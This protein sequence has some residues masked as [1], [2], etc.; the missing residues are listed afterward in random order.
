MNI[1]YRSTETERQAEQTERN[2]WRK[3]AWRQK[4]IE[5]YGHPPVTRLRGKPG[6]TVINGGGEA[7]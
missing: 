3:V 6:L 1:R 5:R 2:L 4:Y 7:A